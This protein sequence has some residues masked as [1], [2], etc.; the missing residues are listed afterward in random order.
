AAP[1]GLQRVARAARGIDGDVLREVLRA[2]LG[3]P[4]LAEDPRQ[5]GRERGGGGVALARER[6]ELGLGDRAAADLV[7]EVVRLELAAEPALDLPGDLGD[8]RRAQD[9]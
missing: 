9:L 4:E 1:L 7:P 2:R 6:V 3:E 5:V 8:Q